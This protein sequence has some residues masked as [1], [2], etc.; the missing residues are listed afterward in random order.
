MD[1]T[2][3]EQKGSCET[4]IHL[5]LLLPFIVERKEIKIHRSERFG[6]VDDILGGRFFRKEDRDRDKRDE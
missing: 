3:G 6:I 2:S 1:S 5:D 4:G